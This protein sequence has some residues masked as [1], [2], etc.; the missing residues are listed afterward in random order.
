MSEARKCD[1]CK[2]FYEIPKGQ[3]NKNAIYDL[4][5]AYAKL[6]FCD[7]N[8]DYPETVR[9]YDLCPKCVE[10]LDKWLENPDSWTP[11]NCLMYIGD[12]DERVNNLYK[13]AEEISSNAGDTKEPK[14]SDPYEEGG[15]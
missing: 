8:R 12:D 10:L 1:R 6:L 4:K 5:G 9:W 14:L 15:L 11:D 13:E 7:N 2:D 3:Q